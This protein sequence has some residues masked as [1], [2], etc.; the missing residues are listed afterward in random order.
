M[1][2]ADATG[3]FPSINAWSCDAMLSRSMLLLVAGCLC[4]TSGAAEA[5]SKKVRAKRVAAM[6]FSRIIAPADQAERL[7]NW[8]AARW[9]IGD[10]A[11]YDDGRAMQGIQWKLRGA[12]FKMKMPIAFN[13]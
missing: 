6:D 5:R 7:R 10:S 8:R 13:N 2:Q 11:H 12:G 4:M 9:A 1:E 3:I